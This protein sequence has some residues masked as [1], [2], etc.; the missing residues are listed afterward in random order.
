MNKKKKKNVYHLIIFLILLKNR[1]MCNN[2]NVY[3]IKC[4]CFFNDH[5]D[6]H[7]IYKYPY[8]T[9]IAPEVEIISY[10]FSYSVICRH[11]FNT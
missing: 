9:L 10:V 4:K 3:V 1:I 11:F 8:N 2:N 6:L 7:T 5:Y